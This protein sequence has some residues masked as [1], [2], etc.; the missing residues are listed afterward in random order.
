MMNQCYS[1]VPYIKCRYFIFTLIMIYL[2][3][4]VSYINIHFMDITE[5]KVMLFVQ[6][7]FLSYN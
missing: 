2:L 7:L 4:V 5:G 6:V 1:F 3:S